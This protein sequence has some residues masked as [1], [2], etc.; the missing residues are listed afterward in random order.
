MPRSPRTS[1]DGQKPHGIPCSVVRGSTATSITLHNHGPSL[2]GPLG[3]PDSFMQFIRGWGDKWMWSNVR[4][5]G[6]NLRLVVREI[7]NGTALWVIYWS[8]NKGVTPHTSGAGWVIY[9]TKTMLKMPRHFY[10]RSQKAGSYRADLFGLLA[11]HIVLVALEEY[12]KI[13]PSK[14][15]ICCGNQGAI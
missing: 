3:K 5:E 9:C 2:E 10:E 13:H 8:Y 6:P 15:K 14:G 7:S 4:N 11:I 1:R 12:Y